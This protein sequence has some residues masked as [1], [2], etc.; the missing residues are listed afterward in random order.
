LQEL[1]SAAGDGVR[2]AVKFQEKTKLPG[3]GEPLRE[4]LEEFV[5]RIGRWDEVSSLN[6]HDLVRVL[7]NEEWPPQ[8]LDQLRK[9]A[10]TES[11]ATVR[12]TRTEPHTEDQE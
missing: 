4:Q 1:S 8:L 9:F 11:T 6:L 3:K 5:R 2:V 12:L 7:E 10:T